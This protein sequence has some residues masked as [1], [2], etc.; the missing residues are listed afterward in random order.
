MRISTVLSVFATATLV[1]AKS[2]R[3]VGRKDYTNAATKLKLSALSP[4]VFSDY[5]SFQHQ[6]QKRQTSYLNDNSQKFAVNGSAIPDVDFDI[7]ESYAGLLPI[8]SASNETRELYFWFFPS[9]NPLASDEITIWLNGGPGCSS[10]EGLLQENGPFLWQYGTF[11][12]VKNP[13]TWVNLTNMVWVEQPVGTGFSQGVP[14]AED[15]EDVAEQF[16][17]FFKNFVDAFALQGRKVYI[18]GESYAGYYVPYIANAMLDANDSTYYNVEAILIY[19][20]STSTDTVQQQSAST[21]QKATN[22]EML[23]VTLSPRRRLR[24]RKRQPLLPQ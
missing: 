9:E 1:A 3:L 8:S 7:G 11:A 4:K 16:L 10:L 6:K 5:S 21:M 23:T 22:H 17:G 19:D 13:Y 24:R 2:T 15:E 18:T 12:P 14:T 20:P